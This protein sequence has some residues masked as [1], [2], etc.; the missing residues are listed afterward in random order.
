MRSSRWAEARLPR[1]DFVRRAPTSR[2]RALLPKSVLVVA[3][4]E[5]D[6][7]LE[8]IE[9]IL[10]ESDGVMVARGDLGVELPFEEVPIAQKKIIKFANVIGRPVITAT[11]MLESMIEHPRPTRAEASDVANAIIDGTDAVMLSAETA[12]GAYPRLA[13]QAMRRIICEIEQ[14]PFKRTRE[15]YVGGPQIIA[16]TEETIAAATDTAQRMLGA[17]I[18]SS[19]P[20]AGP[21]ARI[22]SA[23]RPQ[24]PILA[25]T[26]EPRT[27][28]QLA[29]VWGV[30]PQIVPHC[31]TYEAMVARAR[32]V[33]LARG[34][35]KEGD[36]VLVTAGVPFDVPGTTNVLRVERV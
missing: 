16:T 9:S 11:Q 21:G 14:H 27:F 31:E 34:L 35:A 8:N 28:S 10:R 3:K 1:F 13:V 20:K 4:I 6:S 29:L 15:G 7:A 24:V 33:V 36:R 26:D 17:P 12:A 32:E 18:S 23:H 19:S 2:A 22:V 30:I 5:K 25:L